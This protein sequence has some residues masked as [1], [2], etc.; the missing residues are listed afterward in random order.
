MDELPCWG[1]GFSRERWEISLGEV[2]LG[3]ALRSG[4]VGV[5][6]SSSRSPS[7]GCTSWGSVASATSTPASLWAV[8]GAVNFDEGLLLLVALLALLLLKK[9]VSPGQSSA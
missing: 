7:S 9:I 3:T 5:A 6:T 2:G 8:G 4:A 1:D